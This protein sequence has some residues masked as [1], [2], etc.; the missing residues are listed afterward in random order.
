M[1]DPQKGDLV[2]LVPIDTRVPDWTRP[3]MIFLT[4]ETETAYYGTH[5]REEREV[6]YPKFAWKIQG[7]A[8]A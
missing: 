2:T 6:E 1:P 3:A 5:A 7:E 4:R 8:E